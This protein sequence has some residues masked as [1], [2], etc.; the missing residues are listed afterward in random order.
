MT[1]DGSVIVGNYG[2]RNLNNPFDG[3]QPFVWDE[4]HGM[5]DLKDLL[6]W[7]HGL[8]LEAYPLDVLIATDISDDRRTIV[9]TYKRNATAPYTGFIAHLDRPIDAPTGD[10][11]NDGHVDITDVDLLSAAIR[12]G[13]TERRYDLNRSGTLEAGDLTEMIHGE[14]GTWFGDANLDGQFNTRD[15]VSVFQA[16]QYEDATE[17]NST[18]STGDWDADG[19]FTTRDLVVAFQD[20]GYDRGPRTAAQSVPEP[21]SWLLLIGLSGLAGCMCRKKRSA[22]SARSTKKQLELIDKKPPA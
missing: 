9:G 4:S 5:R 14:I 22:R 2:W 16:G 17:D 12:G 11:S 21:S 13:S 20:G 10:F 8:K 3:N 6:I 19:D 15:L 1:S 7:E 18:W